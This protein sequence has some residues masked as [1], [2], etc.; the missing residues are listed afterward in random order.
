MKNPILLRERHKFVNSDQLV[1]WVALKRAQTIG[2]FF[3]RAALL[4]TI[5][6]KW[7]RRFKSV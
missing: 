6:T 4:Y 2:A 1:L 5:K 7:R 3:G